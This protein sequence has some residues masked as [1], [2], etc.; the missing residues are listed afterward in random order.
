MSAELGMDAAARATAVDSAMKAL[1]FEME[2]T[3]KGLRRDSRKTGS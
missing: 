3:Q 2:P 1:D